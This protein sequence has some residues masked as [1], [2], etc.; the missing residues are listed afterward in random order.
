MLLG[1]TLA[2]VVLAQAVNGLPWR[3]EYKQ[4]VKKGA[5]FPIEH[6]PEFD[7]I[8]GDFELTIETTVTSDSSPISQVPL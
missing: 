8:N 1:V 2:M 4:K 5:L 3:Y 7:M 6:L